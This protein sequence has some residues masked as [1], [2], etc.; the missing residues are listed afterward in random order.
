MGIFDRASKRVTDTMNLVQKKTS[1]T[2]AVN[3][4]KLQMKNM[5]NEIDTLCLAVG[6]RVYTAH[7]NGAE[8]ELNDL[9]EGI[10][11]L[12]KR[13]AEAQVEL[14]KLNAIVRC[15]NCGEALNEGARF[16][17]RCGAPVKEKA[18]ES[19]TPEEEC[20]VCPKCGAKRENDARFCDMCGHD[21]EEA[22]SE[23]ENTEDA[24]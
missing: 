6:K 24:E 23:T 7:V 17:A 14:D 8:A 3:K 5:Q 12:N 22:A 1:D 20:E 11:A 18:P 13:V 21:Y 9:F 15:E 2:I 16:C 4:I 19:E 10:D